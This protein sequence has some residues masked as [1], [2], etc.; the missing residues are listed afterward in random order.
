MVVSPHHYP[1]LNYLGTRGAYMSDGPVEPLYNPHYF[2]HFNPPYPS[3]RLTDE[4]YAVSGRTRAQNHLI[5]VARDAFLACCL[6]DEGMTARLQSWSASI[7][8]PEII[9]DVAAFLDRV[10]DRYGLSRRGELGRI[11]RPPDISVDDFLPEWHTLQDR[12]YAGYRRFPEVLKV[13]FGYVGDE[14]QQPWRWLA[15]RLT[16][17]VFDKAWQRAMGVRMIE[18]RTSHLD[19]MWEPQAGPFRFVFETRCGET[20]PEAKRR[21]MAEAL[22]ASRDIHTDQD[23]HREDRSIHSYGLPKGSP[24]KDREANAIQ[25]AQWLY[26]QLICGDSAAQIAESYHQR[27]K[28]KQDFSNSCG[29]RQRVDRGLRNAILLLDGTPLSSTDK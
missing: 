14:L 19:P 23:A 18:R 25:D 5:T 10:A 27:E 28:H 11:P 8:L 17:H 6:A 20:V 7:G 21:L 13:A 2:P 1:H 26:R 12:L 9:N 15:F 29:C 24:R 16:Y 3:P 4:M 22:E